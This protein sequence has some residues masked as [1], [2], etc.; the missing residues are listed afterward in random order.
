MA[1]IQIAQVIANIASITGAAKQ[2]LE[3]IDKIN[4]SNVDNSL[5]EIVKICQKQS[6]QPATQ[7]ST[8][9]ASI[10]RDYLEQKKLDTSLES[11]CRLATE[12]SFTAVEI[13]AEGVLNK[14]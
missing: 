2:I 13:I 9:E 14:K 11:L 6:K 7:L 1:I 4:N 5:N 12:N 8:K 3:L 10:V